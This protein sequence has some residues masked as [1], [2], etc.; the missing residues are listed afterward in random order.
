M[1]A[2]PSMFLDELPG[3]VK[4]VDLS[5]SAGGTLAAMT[6]WRGGGK[7]AEQGWMDAGVL[8]KK[9]I[10][11]APAAKPKPGGGKTYREGMLVRHDVYGNGKVL[12]ITGSPPRQKI[13]VRFG[14]HGVKTFMAEMAKL[15]I[16]SAG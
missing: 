8:P 12:D 1:Y 3:D 6:E 13:K 14:S 16:I 4:T 9:P 7:A 5:A 2:I 10:E 15:T 11:L